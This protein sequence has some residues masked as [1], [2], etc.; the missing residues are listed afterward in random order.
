MF[1][2]YVKKEIEAL[3]VDEQPL[4]FQLKNKSIF[5]TGA[6][7]LLGSQLILSLLE[8]NRIYNLN[9]KIIA[10]VRSL[11]KAELIFEDYIDGLEFCLGDV[12]QLIVY[13]EPIDFVI[14]GAS[15]TSSLDFVKIPVDTIMTTF[16]GT[17]NILYFALEKKVESFVY[18]SSL[19]VYGT[20][21]GRKDV[22]ED[23]FGALDP[24][25]PRS[26]YSEG[27]RIAETLV[28]SYQSQYKLPA[29]IARLCQ[30]FGPGVNY[31]DNRVFAQFSRSVVEEK[32]I[33]L[34]TEGTT[35]RNYCSIRD[36]IS[37]IL[38]ILIS[39]EVGQA[40]NI[41]NENTMISISDLATKF[42]GMTSNKISV[43][44]DIQDIKNYGYNPEVKLKLKTKKLEQLGWQ[45]KVSLDDILLGLVQSMR[46]SKESTY[47]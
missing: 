12:N 28:I 43:K 9:I 39:G 26:S 24:A 27:K 23:D 14:H 3:L 11:E 34:H 20:F 35:E 8:A 5:I 30:T 41:A 29:K 42:V 44:F 16:Q 21:E 36:S 2:N 17:R 6:T 4:F 32:D 47:E 22:D 1:D 40:Y 19:E 10:L 15:M 45:P 13:E 18:L 37:G 7:G 25:M 46:A 33:I 38:Y 31:Q